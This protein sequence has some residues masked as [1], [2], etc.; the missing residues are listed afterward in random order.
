MF[1]CLCLAYFT[2]H[3]ALNGF[4]GG[5]DSKESACDVRDLGSIPG[6]GR[7]PGEENGNP[8]QCFCLENL[9]DRGAWKATIHTVTESQTQ[10]SD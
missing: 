2:Y 5:S 10:L 1:V 9:K 8:L 7:S 6:P 3:N 4:L